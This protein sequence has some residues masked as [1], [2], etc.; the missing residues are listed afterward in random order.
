M[1]DSPSAPFGSASEARAQ[2]HGKEKKAPGSHGGGGSHAQSSSH[3]SQN[4]GSQSRG[5]QSGGSQNG[6]SKG[7]GGSPSDDLKS[8]AYKDA[9]GNIHHHTRTAGQQGCGEN[10]R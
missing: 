8:R 9:Q 5:S 6:G 2:E 1:P 4:H 10:K 7:S 3:G